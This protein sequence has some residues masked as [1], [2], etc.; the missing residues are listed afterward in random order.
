MDAVTLLLGTISPISFP[1]YLAAITICCLHLSSLELSRSP[2]AGVCK[3]LLH[4]WVYCLFQALHCSPEFWLCSGDLGRARS[5]PTGG[6]SSHLTS[7]LKTLC[8]QGSKGHFLIRCACL[9]KYFW[10]LIRVPEICA[11]FSAP[12][13]RH[14]W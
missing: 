5:T 12:M 4:S 1:L 3:R 6:S 13:D 7:Y 14:N 2:W 11:G 9:P 10:N 8:T